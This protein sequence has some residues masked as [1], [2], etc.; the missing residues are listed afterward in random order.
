MSELRRIVDQLERAFEGRAW[1]GPAL[2]E[3]LEGVTAERAAANPIPGAHS[4]WELVL[5]VAAWEDV[6]RRRLGGETVELTEEENFPAVPDASA[7]AWKA[8]LA[9]LEA[10]NRALRETIARYDAARL[11]APLDRQRSTAYILMHGAIQHDLYHAGQIALLRKGR[12]A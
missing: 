12:P 9:K 3:V 10:G 6:V 11:D 5:H 1:S 8:A 4:I 7:K 2:R